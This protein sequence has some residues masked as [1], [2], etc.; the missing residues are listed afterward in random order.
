MLAENIKR[1]EMMVRLT[2]QRYPA[3]AIKMIE[4]ESEVPA[5][6]VYPLRD[7][8]KHIAICQAFAFARRQ[9]KIIYM[10]KEDHWC[11]NPIL[12]YGMI[13]KEL[14][15][16][17]FRAIHRIKGTS[18]ESADEFV[19]SF[20]C[21]PYGKNN[22][23][24]IAPLTKADFE[25]D[26]TLIYCKND[27]LRLYLMAVDS[28]IHKMIDSSFTPLDS[29]VYSVV[30]SM[31]EG[32]YRITIPDPGEYERGLTPEDDIIFSVPKQRVDEFY[33]GMEYQIGHG[34][35][36]SFYMTMKEEFARPPFY[37]VIFET[38]GLE[39]GDIWDKKQSK[40]WTLENT[41]EDKK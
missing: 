18:I 16:E 32:N 31:L 24:L 27:Q 3:V 28:Q 9:G 10:R 23:I 29:C 2:G 37:N 41:E 35:R 33:K 14:G 12:T 39:T 5:D 36:N 21:L 4:D 30:P 19:D 1:H 15:R 13:D 38:W 26:V 25:P 40:E 20:P 17:G 8:G 6:A 34:D 22:G 7:L 11:W